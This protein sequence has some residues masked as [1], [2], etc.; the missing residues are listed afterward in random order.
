MPSAPSPPLH[1]LLSPSP[2]AL[3]SLSSAPY[4]CSTAHRPYRRR[5]PSDVLRLLHPPVLCH[6]THAVS[7]FL[8]QCFVCML[9]IRFP[10]FFR[11]SLSVALGGFSV[12]I[13]AKQYFYKTDRE[14]HWQGL[15]VSRSSAAER[16]DSFYS[17]VGAGDSGRHCL[18]R[19]L[20]RTG[21]R[22]HTHTRAHL[23]V[24]E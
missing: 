9:P 20:A 2:S 23:H 12:L 7:V 10:F 22:T 8:V 3:C 1:R 19:R 11:S 24:K 21:A 5:R 17:G 13:S 18:Q 14:V 6:S 4:T 16:K 15:D